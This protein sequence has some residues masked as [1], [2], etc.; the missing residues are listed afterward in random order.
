MAK[1]C[2]AFCAARGLAL[3]IDTHRDNTVMQDL[4]RKNGFVYCGV[5]HLAENAKNG[6]PTKETAMYKRHKSTERQNRRPRKKAEAPVF[7]FTYSS[8]LVL[9]A[10]GLHAQVVVQDA[11]CGCAGFRA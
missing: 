5:I 8:L 10:G 1:A 7:L 9:L 3:R 6:W 11:A 2:F 4:L